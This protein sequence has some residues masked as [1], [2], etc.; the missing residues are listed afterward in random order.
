[1]AAVAG[2]CGVAVRTGS[3]HCC[4]GFRQQR[5]GCNAES[6]T[7]PSLPPDGTL[8]HLNAAA[9]PRPRLCCCCC[10]CLHGLSAVDL[11]AT[12]LAYFYHICKSAHPLHII[13]PL[14]L[15]ISPRPVLYILHQLNFPLLSSVIQQN[16]EVAHLIY[17]VRLYLGNSSLTAYNVQGPL[18]SLIRAFN[19]ISRSLSGDGVCAVVMEMAMLKRKP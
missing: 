13:P 6:E 17:I 18:T 16:R 12:Y 11:T 10:C 4:V 14:Y 15:T 8:R 3:R 19:H 9:A 7:S 5:S 1:M 2:A